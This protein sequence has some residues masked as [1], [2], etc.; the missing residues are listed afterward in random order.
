MKEI[1]VIELFAGVGGFR[2]GLEAA[3][4]LYGIVWSNQWEPST[5]IQHASMI[6]EKQFGKKNHSNEDIEKVITD[7]FGTIPDHDLLVGG[8]PCQDYSVARPLSQADG[9][10]GKKGI[11]W[12]SIYN[13]LKQK[14]KRAPKYLILENVDRLLKSPS[15]QRGRDFAI[16]LSSLSE[17]DYAVEWRVINAAEYGF[18][19]RRRRVFIVAYRKDTPIYKRLT[20][21]KNHTNWIKQSGVISAAFPVK[22]NVVT[23]KEVDVHEDAS[24]LTR[25]FSIHSPSS[26]PFE[27]AGVMLMGEVFTA[28][29]VAKYDGQFQC[30]GDVIQDEKEVSDE[31]LIDSENQEKWLYFKGAKNEPR[32][33]KSGHIYQYS[34][35][36]MIFPDPID[37]PSRTIIT[38]EG[39]KTP[40]RFKHVIRC[41][42]GLRRLTPIELELLN[43]FKPN[44]TLIPGISDAKRAFMMGNA[45]V[46]GVVERL[47]Q[48]LA[49]KIFQSDVVPRKLIAEREYKTLTNHKK[50]DVVKLCDYEKSPASN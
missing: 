28:K 9:L 47:G 24:E 23:S 20:K 22:S 36:A 27:N 46:V 37:K 44:H 13:I 26:S 8:F 7:K 16:I 5:K 32:K 45:L 18:P 1:K 50:A 19:Q 4:N 39:G 42:K 12:W 34:E 14:G 43:G 35:G 31:Y 2:L 40:S 41:K 17:L 6:Y 3:S 30:L 10:V 15:K 38:G 48:A 11:L 21:E 49:Q 33:S 25:K 29:V